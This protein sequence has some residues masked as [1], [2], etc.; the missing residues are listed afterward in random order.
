MNHTRATAA[1][2]GLP[3]TA[4]F[5]PVLDT[6]LDVPVRTAAQLPAWQVIATLAGSAAVAVAAGYLGRAEHD[7]PPSAGARPPRPR[8]KEGG[9]T[10]RVSRVTNPWPAVLAAATGAGV[11][12]L[13]VLRPIGS[14]GAS[15]GPPAAPPSCCAAGSA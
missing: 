2:W 7:Q 3:V 12:V 8:L 4:A 14:A 15:A 10:V 6:I 9:R 1:A 11:G 5:V 13:V